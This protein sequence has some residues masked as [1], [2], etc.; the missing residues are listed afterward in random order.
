[1]VASVEEGLAVGVEKSGHIALITLNR[2]DS[3]N[4]VNAELSRQLGQAVVDANADPAI[5]VIVLAAHG[6]AFCAGA[7]LKAIA[8]GEDIFAPGHPEWGFAGFTR[9][10]S[11]KPVICA[12]NGI[13]YG[14]GFEITLACDLVVASRDAQ[15][16]LP[17]V[18]RGLLAGAG[19]TFRTEALLGRRRA[20]EM[21]LTG[22]PIDAD[23]ALSWGLVNRVVDPA[24]V[25]QEALDV[26]HTITANAPL[27]IEASKKAV[28]MG[29]TAGTD[30]DA[31]WDGTHPWEANEHLYTRVFGSHDAHEGATAFAEKR[32]PVWT[33]K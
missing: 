6:R 28:H 24:E 18:S 31:T 27:S 7:D 15:F 4:A 26:A 8:A 20:L 2:P 25:L 11:A 14:G 17:E 29:S 33:G 32:S 13:A 30:W 21:L 10:Y 3:L 22:Q 12:V 23:T 19:G 5:R 1:M 9:L 16:A